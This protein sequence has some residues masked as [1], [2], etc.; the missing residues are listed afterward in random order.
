M[1]YLVIFEEQDKDGVFVEEYYERL[2]DVSEDFIKGYS[3]ALKRNYVN[4][5]YQEI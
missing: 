4:V 2:F 1:N 3:T 5:R